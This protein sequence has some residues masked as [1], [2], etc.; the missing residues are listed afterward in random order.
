[1]NRPT[2]YTLE[3]IE[4]MDQALNANSFALGFQS[5]W[6]GW[7]AAGCVNLAHCAKSYR[8]GRKCGKRQADEERGVVA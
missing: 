1:M 5:A 3:T 8:A 4:A 2:D 7:K 6:R